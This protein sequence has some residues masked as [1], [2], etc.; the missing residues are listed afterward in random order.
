MFNGNPRMNETQ[1]AAKGVQAVSRDGTRVVPD[2]SLADIRH[3]IAQH[4]AGKEPLD[5]DAAEEGGP[6]SPRYRVT[7]TRYGSKLLDIDNGAGGCK[8]LLDA[9]RYE[10]LI[11]DDDPGTIDFVFRQQKV[12]KD[13]RRT[14]VLIEAL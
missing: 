5:P 8:P 7:I 4:D 13:Q 12:K 2:Y 3:A 1:E 9:I 10:G 6:G 14:K 11:P